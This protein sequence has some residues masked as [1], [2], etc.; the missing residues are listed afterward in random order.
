MP[1][2]EKFLGAN[3]LLDTKEA[4]EFYHEI[5]IPLRRDVGIIDTHT[6]HNLRQ[7]VE[8][9]PFPNIWRA[10]VLEPREE[11]VNNDH[12][13]IQLAAKTHWLPKSFHPIVL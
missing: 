13:I 7:I 2:D 8:N 3:W 9:R 12:Y 5:A 10:D 11:Y 1:E 6:H 4:M